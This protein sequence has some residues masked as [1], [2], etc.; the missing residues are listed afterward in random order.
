MDNAH[1]DTFVSSG[2]L[3][4][5]RVLG[6]DLETTG[7]NPRSERIVEY[8][9]IGSDCDGSHI[10]LQSLVYP[11]KRIPEQ[12]TRV[13]GITNSDV[14]ES[15]EFARHIFDIAKLM[16]DAV[17]VGHNVIR[18]DWTFLEM[19]CVRAG[20][21]TPKPRAIIDTLVLAKRLRI[22]GRHTLGHL[23]TR[24]GIGLDN[25]HR[26]SADAGATLL[27]L[28][29]MMKANPRWFRGS[30]DDLQDSLSGQKI[31]DTLGPGLVDLEPIPGTGGNLRESENGIVIAFGKYKGRTLQELKVIDQRYLNWLFSP[32]SPIPQTIS[33]QLR[34]DILD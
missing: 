25:A 1:G 31:D 32:S 27:L 33:N 12:A 5:Y 22:P 34:E 16:D 3:T 11:G 8:A 24:F 6:F 19:E 30:L 10:H 15:G 21:E 28:W 17:I 2:M 18:F 7:F 23:C 4:G 26:A 9:L 13:H 14:R 20:V 29:E